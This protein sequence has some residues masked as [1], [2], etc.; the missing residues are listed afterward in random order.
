MQATSRNVTLDRS[1]SAWNETNASMVR[2]LPFLSTVDPDSD[3][4]WGRPLLKQ[5]MNAVHQQPARFLFSLF[6]IEIIAH[7]PLRNH[8]RVILSK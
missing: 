4:R 6:E 3:I 1:S 8:E 5:R 2:G 7:V